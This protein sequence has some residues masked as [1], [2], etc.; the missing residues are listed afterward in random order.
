MN[1]SIYLMVGKFAYADTDYEGTVALD[2]CRRG[3]QRL[4]VEWDEIQS[5]CRKRRIVDARR[6]CCS[7]L[8]TKG[9][10]FDRIAEA[11][12]YSNHATAMHHVNLAEELIDYDS[13]FRNKHLKF[14]QA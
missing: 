14:L 3:V 8:R 11:V 13:D 6:L 7:H 12:G 1:D 2:Q 5:T 9:W 4:G 10:T